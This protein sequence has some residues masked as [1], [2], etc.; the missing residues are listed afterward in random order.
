MPSMQVFQPTPGTPQP[1]TAVDPSQPTQGEILNY[2]NTKEGEVRFL[3]EPQ[4]LVSTPCATWGQA[5]VV[6]MPAVMVVVCANQ[7]VV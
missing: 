2:T 5:G 6:I 4:Q 7:M 1:Y 3:R